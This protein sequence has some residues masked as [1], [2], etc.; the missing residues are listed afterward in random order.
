MK[1]IMVMA[2]TA[3]GRIAKGSDHFPDWT[4]REDKQFFAKTS[5]EHGVVIMGD[6]TFNTFPAPL[7][8]RLNVVFT[9]DENPKKQ[10]GVK[11]V[12]GE[13]ED[14]LKELEEMGYE[15]AVLGGGAFING[16]FLEKGLIDEIAITIEPKIFGDGI[17]LFKGD[18][19][20]DLKL[21]NTEKINDNSVVLRYKVLY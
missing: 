11:W 14:V 10:E 13:P 4:S 15:S 17:S 5:K 6:K 12:S 3:D 1:I 21:I 8:E 19:D 18:F 16:L 7:K 2:V 9:M 20:V